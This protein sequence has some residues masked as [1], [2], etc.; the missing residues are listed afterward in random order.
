MIIEPSV[1]LHCTLFLTACAVSPGVPAEC[2]VEMERG[3]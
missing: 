3:A 1:L 2:D